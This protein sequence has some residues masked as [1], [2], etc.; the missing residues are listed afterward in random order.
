VTSSQSGKPAAALIPSLAPTEPSSQPQAFLA[1]QPIRIALVDDDQSIH[2][3]MRQIFKRWA[4]DW[5]LDSY[6][7]GKEA[8]NSIPRMQPHAVLMDISMPGITGIDCTRKVKAM[9]PDTPVIMFTA[10]S[11]T[12]SF[13]SSMIAGASGYLVKPS[14]SLDVI[15][16]IKKALAGLPALCLETEKTVIQWL[17]SFKENASEWKLTEREHEIML[18][19]CCNRTDKEISRLLDITAGTV[20]VHLARVFKKLGVHTR[21]DARRRFVGM[22]A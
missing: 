17:R 2:L 19:V 3:A 10:R 6:M 14:P 1:S 16:A 22:D 5:T 18:H 21:N 13:V 20:H 7:D 11:D 9:L 8:I 4:A 12:E 15:S